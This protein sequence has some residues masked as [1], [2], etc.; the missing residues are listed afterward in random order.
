MQMIIWRGQPLAKDTELAK[1]KAKLLKANKT[2]ADYEKEMA[3]NNNT[4]AIVLASW[5]CGSPMF[6]KLTAI[7]CKVQ[8]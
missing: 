4:A 1:S 5:T 3:K 6:Q 2:I 8:R 7:P